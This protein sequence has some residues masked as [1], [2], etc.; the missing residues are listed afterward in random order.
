MSDAVEVSLPDAE[1]TWAVGA[2]LGRCCLPGT[3]LL[4][5]GDLGAGK[6]TFA[7][8]I[9]RGLEVPSSHYVNSPS[10]AILLSYPG[11]LPF[12]HVDLY[13]LGDPD[14]AL[15]L[16]LD[17]LFGGD[18]VAY[19]EWPERLPWLQDDDHL[20]VI[21]SDPPAGDGRQLRLVARGPVATAVLRAF[22]S[23]R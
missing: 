21:L 8:G 22:N 10:F 19:V 1:A 4:A 16:G 9:A 14:E 3:L 23:A 13:R 17:V 18:G 5:E 2:A 11:R 7:Q 15:G 12:H 20:R 6:T